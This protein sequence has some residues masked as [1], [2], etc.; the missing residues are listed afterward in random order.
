MIMILLHLMWL[1]ETEA[2]KQLMLQKDPAKHL[3]K[4]P[5]KHLKKTRN[6]LKNVRIFHQRKLT[7][8]SAVND[9]IVY[10]P[11]VMVD[12]VHNFTQLGKFYFP[13]VVLDRNKK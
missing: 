10:A 7:F 2:L 3:K 9:F 8:P 4:D 1:K 6:K 11:S 5:A 12:E 13:W